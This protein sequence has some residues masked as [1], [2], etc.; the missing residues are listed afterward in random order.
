M[1]RLVI[2]VS[3]CLGVTVFCCGSGSAGSGCS[4][5]ISEKIAQTAERYVGSTHWSYASG[6]CHGPNTNKCNY[7]VYDVGREAGANMP[8]RSFFRGPIG[9]GTGG[10]G[11]SSKVD[12]WKRVTSP[13]RGD[14]VA[15]HYPFDAYHMGIYV[16]PKTT[17]SANSHDIGRNEWPFGTGKRRGV[18]I[19]YWRYK[20]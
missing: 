18:N 19:V 12:Y 7:F 1:K 4:Q 8:T 11:T 9:A 5:S 15:A 3:L 17:V 6:C 16:G 10:W 20:G 2:L 14:V 13:Q